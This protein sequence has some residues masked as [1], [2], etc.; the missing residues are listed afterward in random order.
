MEFINKTLIRVVGLACIS[1]AVY[2]LWFDFTQLL[3]SSNPAYHIRLF[4]YFLP[5][6][7]FAAIIFGLSTLKEGSFSVTAATSFLKDSKVIPECNK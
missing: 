2:F 1:L 5:S 3:F 7:A 4:R 6:V